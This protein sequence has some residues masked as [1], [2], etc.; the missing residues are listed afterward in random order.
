[1]E[2]LIIFLDNGHG[3][4]T[5]GKRSP[6]WSDMPQI[7]EWE[8]TRK[9][10]KKMYCKLNELGFKSF[11]ITPEDEDISITER[12]KRIKEYEKQYGKN[13]CLTISVHLNASDT[14]PNANGWEAHTY[15]G[16]STSDKYSKI[17][18]KHAEK[19][20]NG[21]MRIRKGGADTDPDYDS[22]FGMLRMVGG[23]AILTENGFMTNYEEC[24]KLL[25]EEMENTIVEIHI[26]AIKEI[27]QLLD[28]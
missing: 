21:K 14:A 27:N 19:L 26:E 9:L 16:Y 1:M 18:Y 13:N 2:R 22:S 23:P 10:V 28:K 24:K 20:L 3:K 17:F 4:N 8:Y 15:L 11:I 5:S 25:T 6:K 7:F 12:T